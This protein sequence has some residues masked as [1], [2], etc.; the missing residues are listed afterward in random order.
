MFVDLELKINL[1]Y[2]KYNFFFS[3]NKMSHFTLIFCQ[4]VYIYD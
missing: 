2:R 3:D 1:H 4:K